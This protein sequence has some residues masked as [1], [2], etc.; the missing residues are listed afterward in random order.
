MVSFMRDLLKFHSTIG[1]GPLAIAYRSASFLSIA[2]SC[3]L[4][5]PAPRAVKRDLSLR[6]CPRKNPKLCRG[7]FPVNLAAVTCN[8]RAIPRFTSRQTRGFRRHANRVKPL[9]L[10]S[11][12]DESRLCPFRSRNCASTEL[13]STAILIYKRTSNGARGDNR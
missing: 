6:K 4:S 7:K 9:R 5:K 11:R 8:S 13:K 12:R 2:T 10:V 1:M 3:P